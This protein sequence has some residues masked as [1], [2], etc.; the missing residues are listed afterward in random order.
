MADAKPEWTAPSTSA[1]DGS[2]EPHVFQRAKDDDKS[3]HHRKETHGTRNDIDENTP[4]SNVKA[5]NVFE[6]AKEEIEALVQTIHLKKESPTREKRDQTVQT[7]S[8]ASGSPSENDGKGPNFIQK[9]KQEIEGIMHFKK[10]PRHHGKETHGLNEDI[11]ENT[12]IDEVKAPN[13]FERAKEEI[14]AVVQA[15]HPKKESSNDVVESPKKERGFRYSIGKGLE[16]VLS[17]LGH[18]RD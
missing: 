18:K 13:V 4:L 17:P 5:P 7:E 14:D 1:D 2:N 16:K 9:A 8:N 11:D 15:I 12:P 6:R 10:S 3:P